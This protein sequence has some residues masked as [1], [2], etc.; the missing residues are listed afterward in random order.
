MSGFGDLV[1]R[2]G[3]GP[4][5][6]LPN[7]CDQAAGPSLL[8]DNAEEGDEGEEDDDDDEEEDEEEEEEKKKKI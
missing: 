7:R 5:E 8:V 6:Q 2:G 4:D 1:G 3:V